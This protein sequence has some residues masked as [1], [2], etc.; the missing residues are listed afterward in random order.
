MWRQ[1]LVALL[2]APTIA[3]AGVGNVQHLEGKAFNERDKKHP[4]SR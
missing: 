4:H 2:L 1:T 3:L